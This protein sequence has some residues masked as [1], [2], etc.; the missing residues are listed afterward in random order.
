L[1]AEIL[2]AR[3]VARAALRSEAV[4]T[5]TFEFDEFTRGFVAALVEA[6]RHSIQPKNPIQRRAF[7][8]VWRL[9]GERA[10]QARG[11][12][13]KQEWLR[14]V[15]R[16]RNR[17]SPGQS[18]AFDQF[19][20][21]LRD[22]QLSL[23]ESPNPN[24]EDITFTVSKPFANSVLSKLNRAERALVREAAEVFLTGTTASNVASA[25]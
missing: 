15:V 11:S 13:A 24:Y 21:A 2:F 4:M 8:K 18:G 14:K 12:T 10:E 6:E 1:A 9:I 5:S 19:E 17:M 23:T 20:T 22:L 25:D 7:Y 3:L 16:I